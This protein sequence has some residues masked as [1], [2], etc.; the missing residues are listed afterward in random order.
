MPKWFVIVNKTSGFAVSFHTD[1]NSEILSVDAL[2]A[3]NLERLEVDG[4]L[5]LTEKWDPIQKQK[6]SI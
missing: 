3:K 1:G 5:K 6:V 4:P 2:N